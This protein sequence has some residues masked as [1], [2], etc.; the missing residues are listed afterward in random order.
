[1]CD[2]AEITS[3]PLSE[4]LC[5]DLYAASRAV[6]NAYR[7]ALAELGL[8]YPQ[9]LVL[10]V[11]WDEGTSSV[12][13]IADSLRL[14]HGTLTPLLQRMQD[15]GLVTRRRATDDERVVEVSLTERGLDLRRHADRIQCDMKALLKL[16]D[17]EFTELQSIL[18]RITSNVSR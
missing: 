1:M 12:G 5:F 13:T 15:G 8:T 6:T 17:V 18:R 7:P 11:L 10:I 9:Y 3:P 16:G 4:Q 14:D 2:M